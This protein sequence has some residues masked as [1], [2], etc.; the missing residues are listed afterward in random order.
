MSGHDIV[1]QTCQK[2]CLQLLLWSC[3]ELAFFNLL[4]GRWLIGKEA[5]YSEK[6]VNPCAFV[7]P[8][9]AKL[10]VP[11][12]LVPGRTPASL[13]GLEV[14]PTHRHDVEQPIRLR[15]AVLACEMKQNA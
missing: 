12:L 4:A 9:F 10:C 7:A 11:K 13:A 6:S 15:C 5:Y 14:E 2:A 8:V 3:F 1:K